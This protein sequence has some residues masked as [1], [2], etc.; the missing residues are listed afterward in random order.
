[1]P[2][3][4]KETTER[5]AVSITPHRR[6]VG[7]R[8]PG[9][10]SWLLGY[11]RRHAARVCAGV[12]VTICG[13]VIATLDPL[14]MRHLID[15]ALPSRRLVL[16]LFTVVALA[17]CFVGRSALG[18]LSS[19]LSFR[20]SQLLGQ[21][22]RAAV[23]AHMSNL[24]AD[25]HENTLLGEKLSRVGQDVDQISQFGSDVTSSVL[26]S[27]VFFVTNLVIM[28]VLNWRMTLAVL[29][30]LPLFVI[31]R[32]WF[33]S[34]IQSRADQAQAS[35]GRANSQLAEHLSAIPELQALGAT[36]IR[37]DG[38]IRFW[39]GSM[40]SQ[41]RQR[42]TEI[43]FSVSVS[44]VLSVAILLVLGFG[45]HEYLMNLISLGGLVA[46]YAYVTRI[47]EP[48]SSAMEIYSRSQRMFA[49]ARRVREILRE[50]PSVPD[51]G[52]V[53][54]VELPL[55]SGLRCKDVWFAYNGDASI[56][57]GVNMNIAPGERIAIAG[58]SGSGKSTLSKLLARVAD[59]VA[60]SVTFNGL[61]SSAYSLAVY[62]EAVCYVSQRPVLF[63]GTIR[64]NL[65][66]AKPDATDLE[67]RSVLDVAQLN[68]SIGRLP[69]G[70]DTPLGPDA[71]G[72]SGGERQRLALARALLRG[73]AVLILDESTSALDVPTEARVFEAVSEYCGSNMLIIISHRLRS[74][75]WVDRIVLMDSGTVVADGSHAALFASSA[76][77]RELYETGVADGDIPESPIANGTAQ[78]HS[79]PVFAAKVL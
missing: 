13:G 27:V 42:R 1:M 26:R 28:A 72:L 12:G 33:R 68:R 45:A 76:L 57:S 15:V 36:G 16:S 66:L 23:L 9:D 75:R 34:T 58:R 4:T 3:P 29:P 62:R 10:T 78:S 59:P 56:L 5:G 25:W 67:I 48:L 69:Q 30:L 20:V 41:W 6:R 21:D 43:A 39:L 31:V 44:I 35:L 2:L 70:V 47:F 65:R 14:L 24:S 50:S 37:Q 7:S 38:T 17:L 79:G 71:S 73:A 60:G 8:D 49:S 54:R 11:L 22:L 51:L 18:G 46:F 64:D 53:S 63:S 32:H 19:T 61:L 40:E 74:L 52:R 77:Y 55:S